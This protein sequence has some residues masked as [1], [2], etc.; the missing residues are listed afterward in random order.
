MRVIQKF[1]PYDTDLF[2][3]WT[4]LE[5]F[6]MDFEVQEPSHLILSGHVNLVHRGLCGGAVGFA[7]CISVKSSPTKEG[8]GPF[9]TNWIGNPAGGYLFGSKTGGNIL[10]VE[11]HYGY[12]S[13]DG[14]KLIQPG[15][16]RVE[17]WGVSHSGH[18]PGTDGLIEVLTDAS[19]AESGTYNQ[20]VAQIIPA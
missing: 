10:G 20:L 6:T 11:D 14:Y 9:P 18:A 7:L 16:H 3:H 17:V 8:L 1:H 15:W 19:H 5:G 13:L 12:P 4:R 2:R